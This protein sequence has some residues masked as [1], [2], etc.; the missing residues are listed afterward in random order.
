MMGQEKS[1]GK[2]LVFAAMVVCCGLFA[3]VS[4]RGQ[5]P[6]NSPSPTKPAD[7]QKPAA[8]PADSNPFPEDTNSVP[9]V[10]IGDATR[11]PDTAANSANPAPALPAEDLDPARSP[12]DPAPD[13]A[14]NS[15]ES[16]S[17]NTDLDKLIDPP[18]ADKRRGKN[19]KAPEPE[20]Q[21]TAKEDESVGEYYLSKRNWK[22]ALSR[23]ESAVVLDPDNPDVYWGLAEAQ[24]NLGDNAAAKA[25]YLKLLDYDPDN[26]HA[27]D[28]RKTLK[29]PE[30]A[31]APTASAGHPRP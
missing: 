13:A 17:R 2:A 30:L 23:F 20:H 9:V 16:S 29:E 26:K 27:K 6:A 5:A 3:A 4:S 24:H 10:P 11:V 28:A 12:D 7:T 18:D 21:E 19:G 22:A 14:S 8:K 15:S 1:K 25:N 31:N